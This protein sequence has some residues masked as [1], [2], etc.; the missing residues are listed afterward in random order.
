MYQQELS[1]I[2]YRSSQ[3]GISGAVATCGKLTC[4]FVKMSN[5]NLLFTQFGSSYEMVNIPKFGYF[6][7]QVNY[8]VSFK[9]YFGN[10]VPNTLY[11][12]LMIVMLFYDMYVKLMATIVFFFFFCQWVAL[13]VERRPLNH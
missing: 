1:K 5:W 11:A 8:S 10:E 13:E 7:R 12:M 3:C 4:I 6:N 9:V 2:Y